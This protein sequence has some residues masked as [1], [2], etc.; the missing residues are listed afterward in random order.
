M[1]WMSC[2]LVMGFF[3]AG[4]AYLPSRQKLTIGADIKL[5]A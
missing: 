5:P 1:A 4:I 3:L 2:F